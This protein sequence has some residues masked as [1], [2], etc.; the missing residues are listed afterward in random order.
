[1]PAA[2]T[3][4]GFFS[5]FY[6]CQL[7]WSFCS[8]PLI[9][10]RLLDELCSRISLR[11]SASAYCI[12][13]SGAGLLCR[14]ILLCNRPCW[15][16]RSPRKYDGKS[17]GW[18]YADGMASPSPSCPLTTISHSGLPPRPSHSNSSYTTRPSTSATVARAPTS[19]VSLKAPLQRLSA[20]S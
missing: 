15:R 11:L 19:P 7:H 5:S 16:C 13:S 14:I 2:P 6:Y 18:Q 20:S 10:S 9:E 8:R 12:T 4:V 1:M 17:L 3:S